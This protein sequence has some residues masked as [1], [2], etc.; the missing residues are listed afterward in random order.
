MILVYFILNCTLHGGCAQGQSVD[1]AFNIYRV[2]GM[3][4]FNVENSEK[5]NVEV[6]GKFL[7]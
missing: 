4:L 7:T 1:K 5:M 6:K 2:N 3:H